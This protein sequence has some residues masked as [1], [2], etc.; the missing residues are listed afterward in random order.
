MDLKAFKGGSIALAHQVKNKNMN[1]CMVS[2]S[3]ENEF[4]STSS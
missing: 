4:S 2:V 1:R 3:I